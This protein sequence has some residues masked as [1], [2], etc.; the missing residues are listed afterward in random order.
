MADQPLFGLQAQHDRLGTGGHDHRPRPVGGLGGIRVAHPHPV[1]WAGQVD[2]ADLLGEHLC[3]EPLGLLSELDHQLG[4]HHPVGEAGIV[5]HVGGEHQLAAGLVAGGR[6]L[7]LDDQGS[8][9]G[10]GGVDR[11][12]QPGRP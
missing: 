3:A 9:V 12:G 2:P 7:A 6:R 10:P 5:L 1:G 11:G 4:A 8:E